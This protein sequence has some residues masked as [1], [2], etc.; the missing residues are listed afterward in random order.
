MKTTEIAIIGAGPAGLAAAIEAAKAGAKVALIDENAKPGGQLFKQIHKFFGSQKHGAG[1]RGIQIG[2]DL[3]SEAERI[4]VELLLNTT[5]YGLF[6]DKILG[7]T[8]G[9]SSE[10]LKAERIIIAT[11][12]TENALAFPGWTL[13]GVMTAGAAQ[14]MVNIHRVLPG[15]R[16]LMVGAG[17]VGLIVSYQL[18]QAGT[19]VVAVVEA[20]P[21]IGGYQVHAA[22]LERA[23]VKILTSH[24]VRE[25]KGTDFLESAV[26]VKLNER[27]QQIDGTE[28]KL[29]VDTICLA[30]GLTPLAELAWM[31][32]CEFRYAGELR[33]YVPTLDENMQT[34]QSGIY[35][36]GDAAGIEEAS[37]AMEEG[38]IAGVAA[39]ESLG[40]I[41]LVSATEVKNFYRNGLAE[42]RVNWKPSRCKVLS[43]EN[44]GLVPQKPIALI[45]CFQNIPCNP[46]ETSCAQNAI[47]VGKP[48]TNLP[49]LDADRCIGCGIC[50]AACPGLA[51]FLLDMTFSANEALVTIPYEYFPLPKK[52]DEVCAVNETGETL[53]R[54]R[55]YRVRNPER[56]DKTALVSIVVPKR[57]ACEIREINDSRSK[58]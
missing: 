8:N 10:E 31:A 50:V 17:N 13:P 34:T 56:F 14:T 49:V 33:A 12:A 37:T 11:G 28:M 54:A 15:K 40:R 36:A 53:C 18:M 57:F 4:G 30:V 45:E 9:D 21:K 24:T 26:I 2:K 3:C 25:A 27:W 38:R 16:V 52:G 43:G 20:T 23:G 51:I 41:E 35:I 47:T 58:L 19:A 48:I 42:L 29:D 6:P 7:L 46:C 55:I 22:K 32:G 5:V 39:A 1:I 44:R